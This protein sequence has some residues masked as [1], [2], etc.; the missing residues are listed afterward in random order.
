MVGRNSHASIFIKQEIGREWKKGVMTANRAWEVAALLGNKL[1][2]FSI[3]EATVV[4]N[5]S[6][7][8][9]LFLQAKIRELMAF[10]HQFA[11]MNKSGITAL[12][13]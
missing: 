3:K 7:S 10:C 13:S 9:L 8:F 11:T 12:R 6:L 1:F 4:P 5:Q 2:P